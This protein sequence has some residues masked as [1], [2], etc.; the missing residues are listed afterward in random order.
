MRFACDTGGTVRL[1]TVRLLY[2]RGLYTGCLRF[3]CGAGAAG[4]TNGGRLPRIPSNVLRILLK[5]RWG[6]GVAASPKPAVPTKANR[7]L[8]GLTAQFIILDSSYCVLMCNPYCE[9]Y[10]SRGQSVLFL[11]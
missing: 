9:I 10:M 6:A 5:G 2:V 1:L 8:I 3:A 4:G 7:C 11:L